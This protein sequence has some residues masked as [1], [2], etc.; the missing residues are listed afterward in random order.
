MAP[1]NGGVTNNNRGILSGYAWGEKLDWV[2]FS[3][4]TIDQVGQFHGS[5]RGSLVGNLM[6]DCRGCD[7]RT[8]W[9]PASSRSFTPPVS[10]N[11]L[12]GSSTDSAIPPSQPFQEQPPLFD[13]GQTAV[14]TSTGNLVTRVAPGELL[15]ISVKLTNF[16]CIGVI[17]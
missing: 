7:V 16:G 11:I 4:V 8:D 1:V 17:E 13:V 14:D 12:T 10:G 2:N 5:A 9:R 15:P 6:F 3:G